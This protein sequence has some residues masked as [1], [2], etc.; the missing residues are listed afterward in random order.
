MATAKTAPAKKTAAAPAAPAK[1]TAPARAA[2]V[3]AAPA[4]EEAADEG[5]IEVGMFAKFL[6]YGADTPEAEQVLVQDEV[7]EIVGITEPEGED[8]GGDPILLA[9]NPDFN[10]KKKEHPDTNPANIEVQVFPEEIELVDAPEAEEAAA[11][12][13][14]EE[15]P[16]PAPAP[17]KKAAVKSAPAKTP[18]AKTPAVKAAAKTAPGKK[19]PAVKT[20]A[21]PAPVIDPDDLPDLENEDAEVL[22]L[23]EGS[24]DLIATAQELEQAVGQTEF[25]LG[26]VLFHLRKDKIHRTL[27]GEDKKP[28]AEYNDKGGFQSFLRDYFNIDYRKAMYL[29]E[30]YQS[31]TIAGIAD[32]GAIVAAMGWTKAQK[33][34]K[35]MLAEGANADELIELA[36]SNTVA[37]LTVALQEQVSVGGSTSGG[38]TVTRTSLKF[39]LFEEQGKSTL[40]VLEAAQEQMGLKDLNEALFYVVNDWATQNAGGA[41]TAESAPAQTAKPAVKAA[42]AAKAAPRRAV[43]AK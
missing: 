39:R 26:G 37:D 41:A 40:A 4:V 11:E 35:P 15:A 2:A 36:T 17:A 3:A 12:E 29:I 5:T 14:V 16:A 34:A 13:V 10:E 24:T 21:E 27:V 28:I 31:F 43:A 18:A 33:I 19:T 42:P 8:P 30:I 32:P 9:G 6:G 23:I 25:Q 20:P 1:K 38:T 7:Y 22:A